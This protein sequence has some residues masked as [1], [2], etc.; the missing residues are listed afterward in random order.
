MGRKKMMGMAGGFG[1]EINKDMVNKRGITGAIGRVNCTP[2]SALFKSVR[3]HKQ[4][5]ICVTQLILVTKKSSFLQSIEN[6]ANGLKINFQFLL[7]Q[8]YDKSS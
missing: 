2:D 4:L 5:A 6:L 7:A 8:L 1:M 3:I